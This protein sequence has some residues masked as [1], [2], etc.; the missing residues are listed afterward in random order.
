MEK[1]SL[2]LV[3]VLTLFAMAC[4]EEEAPVDNS[5]NDTP[6]AVCVEGET[7]ENSCGPC[8]CVDGRWDCLQSECADLSFKAGYIE[9]EPV[10]FTLRLGQDSAAYQSSTTHI[11]YA[12]QPADQTPADKPLAI[13]FNGGPGASTSGILFSFNTAK[14]SLDS[15]FNGGVPVGDHPN[16]WTRFANLLYIDA[17]GTGLSYSV[18]ADPADGI[19]RQ[20]EFATKNFNCFLDAAD[21]I[22]VILR[23]LNRHPSIKGNQVYLVGES[24]GGVRATSML[25]LLLKYRDYAGSQMAYQDVALVNEIQA[26]FESLHPQLAGQTIAP[27]VIAQQFSRQILIQAVL[28]GRFE[29]ETRGLLYEEPDSVVFQIAAEE[30]L[31][32]V[33]CAEGDEECRPL[34]NALDFVKSQAQRD[35]YKYA[36]QTDWTLDLI[37]EIGVTLQMVDHFSAAV[38]MDIS[39]IAELVS[40]ERASAYRTIG[41]PDQEGDAVD[42]SR[43]FGPLQPWDA[44]YNF[45]NEDVGGA[46]YTD[47]AFRFEI[48]PGDRRF[49]TKFLENVVYVDTFVTN[50]AYDLMVYGPAQPVALGLHTDL[51][52]S[53]IHDTELGEMQLDYLP[54]AFGIEDLGPRTIRFPHYSQSGHVVEIDQPAQLLD[55][56]IA[57]I[58]TQ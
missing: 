2:G 5:I 28:S 24:F 38:G 53:C 52:E 56:L 50:A 54:G 51:L 12:F 30:G 49:G 6:W 20:A 46:F 10:S 11:W 55:D 47:D 21:F 45:L 29:A 42:F 14:K 35:V 31:T 25:H 16:S 1:I 32:F 9:L 17:R 7:T 22:R 43:V 34:R 36:E 4:E 57:W 3:G 41:I 18:M 48:L 37:D 39:T 27:E 44:Y 58:D 40:T 19:A 15:R 8:T 23:F 33:P 13:F 26:H